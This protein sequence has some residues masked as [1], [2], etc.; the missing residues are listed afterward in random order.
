MIQRNEFERKLS[1]PIEVLEGLRKITTTSA[2]IARVPAKI[3]SANS[4]G[5]IVITYGC[6]RKS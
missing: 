6:T 3:R 2:M 5:N 4:L 1:W